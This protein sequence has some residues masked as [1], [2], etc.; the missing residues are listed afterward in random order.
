MELR[1]KINKTKI[2]MMRKAI[3]LKKKKDQKS[4]SKEILLINLRMGKLQN[5]RATLLLQRQMEVL[6]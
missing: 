4:M 5:L 1:L 3:I 2:L 6:L